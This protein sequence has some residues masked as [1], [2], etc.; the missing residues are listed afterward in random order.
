MPT[1]SDSGKHRKNIHYIHKANTIGIPSESDLTDA[2]DNKVPNQNKPRLNFFE[3]FRNTL[4][5]KHKSDPTTLDLQKE[6]DK[7]DTQRRWSETSQP[8]VNTLGI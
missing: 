7:N 6:T 3:G 8:T 5:P 2:S 1:P 4:R